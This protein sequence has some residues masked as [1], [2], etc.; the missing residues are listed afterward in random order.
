MKKQEDKCED[1]HNNC[2]A[3]M[4]INVKA[5][6]N[7]DTHKNEF[8]FAMTAEYVINNVLIVSFEI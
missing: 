4:D 2:V 3:R 5:D 7:Y 6:D 1:S 8:A